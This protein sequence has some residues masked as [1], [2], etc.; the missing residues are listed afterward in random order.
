MK[1]V[2]ILTNEAMP[3]IIKI[4]WTDNS[5]EQRMKELD[6]TGTPL[7][8]TCYFAK[9]VDDP[10]FVESKLHEAFDEFRIRENR[11]FF[12]MSADQAKAALEIASGEDVTPQGDVVETESDKAALDRERKRTRFNF[13]QIGI[14]PGEILEFKKDPSIKAKVVENDQIEFRGKITSLSPAA[15]II[16]QEMGYKWTKIAGPQFWMYKGKTLYELNN[17]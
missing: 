14:E 11:E 5:V 10:K 3:G 17:Q 7:P 1:T 15:L 9:R 2:Y 6:K 8:F 12:R 16:V 13:A 4:G